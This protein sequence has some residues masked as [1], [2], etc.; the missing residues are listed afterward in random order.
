MSTAFEK[1]QGY[2]LDQSFPQLFLTE[3]YV[4]SCIGRP[5][6]FLASIPAACNMVVRKQKNHIRT[7]L[8]VFFK[9]NPFP[10]FFLHSFLPKSLSPH[11]G[12][13]PAPQPVCVCKSVSPPAQA[14][15]QPLSPYRQS[16]PGFRPA[17]KVMAFIRV[18]F[19]I[20]KLFFSRGC[21]PDV[22]FF[23][24]KNCMASSFA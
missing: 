12:K 1:K 24:V 11:R 8:P 6:M 7:F 20:K 18:R 17:R 2:S 21:K 4:S 5:F 14:A 10:L 16:L 13:K 3:A 15:A 23:S 19:Q 9:H 22:L